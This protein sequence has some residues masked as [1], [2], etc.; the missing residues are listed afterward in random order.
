[1]TMGGGSA[2][3]E[4]AWFASTHVMF[5]PST[6]LQSE[7]KEAGRL[8]AELTASSVVESMFRSEKA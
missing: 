5:V 8:P 1:M 3:P 7:V 6:T 2:H 4:Q